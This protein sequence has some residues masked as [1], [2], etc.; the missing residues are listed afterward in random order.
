MM[1][2]TLLLRRG[3]CG[4]ASAGSLSDHTLI[5]IFADTPPENPARFEKE[6]LLCFVIL[7]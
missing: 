7:L 6:I 3:L 4:S 1:T 5:C 2:A